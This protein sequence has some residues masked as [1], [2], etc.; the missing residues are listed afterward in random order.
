MNAAEHEAACLQAYG[1]AR[2]SLEAGLLRRGTTSRPAA[3][4]LDIDDTV[5]DTSAFSA[6]LETHGLMISFKSSSAFFSFF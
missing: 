5:L 6:F 4:I 1:L 3:V 2:E